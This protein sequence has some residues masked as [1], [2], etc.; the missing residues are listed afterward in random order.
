MRRCDSSSHVSMSQPLVCAS[1]VSRDVQC[2]LADNVDAGLHTSGDGQPS[3][4]PR[5]IVQ[6]TLKG[7]KIE[8]YIRNTVNVNRRIQCPL[9]A[10]LANAGVFFLTEV[11]LIGSITRFPTSRA[12]EAFN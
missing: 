12:A 5:M 2:P 6:S 8:T 3:H 1:D 11:H 7:H 10:H 4:G 9:L